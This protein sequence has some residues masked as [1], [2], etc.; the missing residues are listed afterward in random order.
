VGR[1][2]F[3]RR[4]KSRILAAMGRM[5]VVVPAGVIAFLV[6]AWSGS[7][8]SSHQ[9]DCSHPSASFRKPSVEGDHRE[10]VVHFTCAGAKQAGTIYLPLPT[11]RHPAI[12]WVHGAGEATRLSYGPLVEAFVQR[13]IAFFSYDKRGVGESEGYCCPGDKGDFELLTADAVGAVE[14]AR[15][16]AGIDPAQVGFT[17]ASQ[18]GWI[19]PQAGVNSRH[20]AFIALAS[21]GV[22]RYSIVHE[23]ERF[24]GGEESGK[25]RPSE[26]EIAKKLAS[27]KPSGYD[28]APAL[29]KLKAPALWLFGGADRNV[30]PR[31][32][33]AALRQ[34]KA[35]LHKNWTIIVYP[36]A[37]HGLFDAKPTDPRAI[38]AAATWVRRHVTLAH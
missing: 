18:A 33:A 31:Q 29:R 34:M 27:V 20:V 14:A 22:L 6:S 11:G 8:H 13:G 3:D 23:Y 21:P 2:T 16:F 12:V 32:S 9:A 24:T 5:W 1:I 15:F 25:P 10:V 37:G 7:N 26:G 36:G 30:P 28:P 38:P 35:K 17:G 4:R 19:A